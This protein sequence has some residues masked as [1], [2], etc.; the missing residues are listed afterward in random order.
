MEQ[1]CIQGK[2]IKIRTAKLQP[3]ECHAIQWSLL[4]YLGALAPGLIWQWTPLC[5]IYVITLPKTNSNIGWNG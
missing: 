5:K 4:A 2:R 3:Y 1:S